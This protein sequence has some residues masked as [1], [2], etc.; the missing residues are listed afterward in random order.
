MIFLNAWELPNVFAWTFMGI[1]CKT[2]SKGNESFGGNYDFITYTSNKR[3]FS[4][5]NSVYVVC[6]IQI[7]LTNHTQTLMFVQIFDRYTNVVAGFQT[8][9]NVFP[10]LIDHGL[11]IFSFKWSKIKKTWEENLFWQSAP[12]LKFRNQNNLNFGGWKH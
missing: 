1:R 3:E 12:K 2:I 6:Q 9:F 7:L 10:H 11:P 4:R 8:I 5:R